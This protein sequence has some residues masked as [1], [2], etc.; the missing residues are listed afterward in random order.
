MTTP[1]ASLPN[2]TKVLNTDDGEVGSVLNGFA[3]DPATG[4][5]T[6]YEVATKYGIEQWERSKFLLL[7]E[8]E[9]E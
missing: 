9:T 4:E 6:E 3:Y 7:S 5:W 2:G 1:T 8:L